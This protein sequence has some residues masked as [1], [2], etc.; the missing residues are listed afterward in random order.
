MERIEILYDHYK[1]SCELA[2]KNEKRRDNLFIIVC[3]LIGL[4]F[5]FSYDKNS[6][7]GLI[8]SWIKTNYDYDLTFSSN[9]IQAILWIVLFIFTLH[10]LGLNINL[11][12]SYNYIHKLENEINA[13]IFR[14][15][16]TREGTSYL[17]NY[18]ILNNITYISYRIILPIIYYFIILIKLKLEY[19][20]QG[21]INFF[22]LFQIILGIFCIILIIVY[23]I[24]NIIDMLS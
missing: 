5:L 2:R 18:P 20:A 14:E 21:G 17:N 8:Q 16:I 7:I 24:E 13:E 15:T 22:V 4:L 3:V 19:I 6:V 1:E 12:R 9:I 10:Y 23:L 11:D